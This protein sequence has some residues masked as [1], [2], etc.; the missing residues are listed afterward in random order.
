[1][2]RI[3]L[4]KK[5]LS[6]DN[7]PLICVTYVTEC[8]SRQSNACIISLNETKENNKLCFHYLLVNAVKVLF[9]NCSLILAIFGNKNSCIAKLRNSDLEMDHNR[10]KH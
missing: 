10:T 3:L 4:K 1:M 8:I 2:C 5:L 9:C 6:G 7:N